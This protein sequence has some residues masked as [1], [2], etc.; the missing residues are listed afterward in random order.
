[1]AAP[2]DLT[3]T[4]VT[5]SRALLGIAVRTIAEAPVE[6]TLAQHRVLVLLAARGD[7]TVGDIADGLGV[8][9]SNATRICD[10]LQRLDLVSRARS[11]QDKRV[12]VVSLS[13][14]GADLVKAVTQR[15]RVEINK[16]LDRMTPQ[17]TTQVVEALALFNQAA[18]EVEDRDW[19]TELW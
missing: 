12:V 10:R 19:A 1:M 2:R 18:G 13:A 11:E 6:V 8:N 3:G 16:V 15:R 9:P 14:H 17:Q 5:A 4:F 7:Q